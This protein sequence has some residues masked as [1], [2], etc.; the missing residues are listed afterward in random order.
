MRMNLFQSSLRLLIAAGSVGGFFG[1][2]GLLAHSGKPVA[3]EAPAA[4]VAP[5]PL[6]PQDLLT[7]P[8]S[9]LQPLQPFQS[10]PP[11]R[12]TSRVRLRTGGS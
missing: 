9:Q 3:A 6:H 12:S 1:G 11:L 4:Q 10:Q 8:S 5:A 2:W 7:R